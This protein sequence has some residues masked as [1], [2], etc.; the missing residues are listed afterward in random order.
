MDKRDAK[1]ERYR[2][3]KKASAITA[4]AVW[5]FLIISIYEEGGVFN[6]QVPKCMFATMA[7]F[8]ILTAIFKGVEYLESSE[9]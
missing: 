4:V 1:A 5:I 2:W 8:S 3:I 6:E 7:V 9:A